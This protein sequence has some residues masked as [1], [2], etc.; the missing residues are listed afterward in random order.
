MRVFSN[1]L[2]FQRGEKFKYKK[3]MIGADGL[4]WSIYPCVSRLADEVR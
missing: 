1:N 2:E 3:K 4:V